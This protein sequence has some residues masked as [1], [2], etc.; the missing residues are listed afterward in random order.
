MARSAATPPRRPRPT[1]RERTGASSPAGGS[2]SRSP[3]RRRARA[4]G[5]PG[6]RAS[7]AVGRARRRRRRRPAPR[8]EREPAREH[9]EPAQQYPLVARQELV[10]PLHGR[11]QRL[12]ALCGGPGSAAEQPEALPQTA[13]DLLD[14]QHP[15][16][17]R[18]ELDGERQAVHARA[19]AGNTLGV[20]VAQSESRGAPGARAR[21][22][23]PPRPNRP[24]P[25]RTPRMPATTSAVPA[26]R[27]RP[28]PPVVT[29]SWPTRRRREQPSA[30]HRPS[31]RNPPADARSCR[32]PPTPAGRRGRRR[33]PAARS[34]PA[35]DAPRA[36]LPPPLP[37]CRASASHARST[38][39]TPPE[40]RSTRS[41]ASS[42]ASRVLPQPPGPL[43]V[44][45]RACLST[46]C[47]WA[48]SLSRPTKLVSA[49]GRP[50]AGAPP[51]SGV[52]VPA[53]ASNC[54]A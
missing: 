40:V 23:T 8:P 52:T 9:R 34:A 38:H 51:R 6:T 21:R 16:P 28:P 27:P 33:R 20:A 1:V 49:T 17:C 24:T 10:T 53:P 45:R 4:T 25:R 47:S 2:A 48:N 13:R 41:A 42:S 32:G 22:T 11:A 26:R 5:R 19:H 7:R 12:L 18:R 35:A 44:T 43:R 14:R 30:A 36:P 39:Q 46:S 50:R 31:R 37:P 15:Q 54:S 29:G 3:A